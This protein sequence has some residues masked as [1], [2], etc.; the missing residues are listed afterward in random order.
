MRTCMDP[1]PHPVVN[2][3]RRS[4]R[5][6]IGALALTALAAAA[7]TL[8]WRKRH[9]PDAVHVYKA[10]QGGF[11]HLD[12]FR[13][14]RP[15]PMPALLLFHGGG[16]E[17]GAPR[18]FHVPARALSQRLGLHVFCVEYRIHSRHRSSPA[19]AVQDARDA[20]R[21]V[22]RH[23]AVLNV[24]PGRIAAGGGSAGGHLAACLGTGAGLADQDTDSSVSTRPQA[25][26]LLN[27]MLD[28]SPG[29]PDHAQVAAHWQALSPHH[30]VGPGLPPTLVL[31][32]TRDAE[33][34]VAT[35]QAFCARAHAVGSLCE[36]QFFEGA[37]HGFFNAEV[38]SGRYV[39]PTWDAVERFLQQHVLA[40][41]VA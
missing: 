18:Q 16:W 30:H 32:G 28:L 25:L 21:H 10:T 26:I 14:E 40:G 24:D 7:G 12:H 36:A 31:S 29:R 34:P 9:Y 39:K 35:V 33:V 5:W 27:P 8:R 2:P 37:G 13:S 6:T 20:I 3:S 23:A 1:S 11:L 15:G 4:R 22:R 38:A 17:L 19:D 41:K